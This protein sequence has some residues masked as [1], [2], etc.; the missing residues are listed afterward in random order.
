M[1]S[2][3]PTDVDEF[4]RI[5]H[6]DWDLAT[7]ARPARVRQLFRRTVPIGVDHGTVG[8]LARDSE[9]D[10]IVGRILQRDRIME[11]DH[12]DYTYEE[13]WEEVIM[14]DLIDSEAE[15]EMEEIQVERWSLTRWISLLIRNLARADPQGN[16]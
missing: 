10:R 11:L 12:D 8:I 3:D 14:G 6:E 15:A 5:D 1:F 4:L 13:F 7:A 9:P 2:M 16:R